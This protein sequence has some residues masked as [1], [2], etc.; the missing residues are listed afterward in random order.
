MNIKN[1][2]FKAKIERYENKLL[3]LNPSFQRHIQNISD[4]SLD[5]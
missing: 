4:K 1:V 5:K 2:E 3:T